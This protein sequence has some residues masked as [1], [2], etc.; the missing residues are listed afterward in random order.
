MISKKRHWLKAWNSHP[1]RQLLEW[2]LLFTQH[3]AL[4]EFPNTVGEIDNHLQLA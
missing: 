4:S 1:P 3:R 2:G